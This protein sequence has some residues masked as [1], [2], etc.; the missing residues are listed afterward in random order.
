MLYE[1]ERGDMS[2]AVVG[3]AMLS[4]RL[5]AYREPEFLKLAELLRNADLS[6]ANLEF[7]F[8]DFEH[9]WQWTQGTYTRS[10]PKNLNELKWQGAYPRLKKLC[11]E[12][13]EERI[14]ERVMKWR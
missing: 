2:I 11:Q 13:R 14:A 1:A 8:H 12:L 10:D 3:D 7:L 6:L 5:R 9:A 4:R